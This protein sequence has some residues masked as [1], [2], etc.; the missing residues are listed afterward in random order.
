MAR[1]RADASHCTSRQR[2]SHM[3]ASLLR[4]MARATHAIKRSIGA[5]ARLSGNTVVANIRSDTPR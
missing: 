5:T 1:V 2:V 3:H 4:A